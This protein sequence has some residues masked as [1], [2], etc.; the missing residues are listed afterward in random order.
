M[1]CSTSV[2]VSKDNN[3]VHDK[4]RSR[5]PEMLLLMR[6]HG[7]GAAQCSTR[8]TRNSFLIFQSEVELSR[9]VRRISQ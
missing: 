8:G 3:A 1:K 9:A 2:T 4:S 7:N 5:L 6:L